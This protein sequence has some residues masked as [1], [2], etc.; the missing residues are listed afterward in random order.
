MTRAKPLDRAFL[1]WCVILAL[2]LGSPSGFAIAENIDPNEDGSQYGWGENFGW[3]NAEPGGD[4]GSGVQVN[5][6][7]LTG[8]LFA[9]NLGWISLSCQ[10]T[11]SCTTMEYGITNDGD[12][13][14]SGFGW[15]ENGGWVNFAPASGGGVTIDPATGQFNGPVWAE[16]AG[17]IH[18][19]G[20]DAVLFGVTTAWPDETG[21][22][23]GDADGD[24]NVDRN[25]LT[26][27]IAARNTP[28]T[29]PDDPRDVDQDGTIT[30]L[31][32]R[33]AALRCD[34]PLCAP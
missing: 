25:D 6:D 12:G 22:L 28:S 20:S 29:G 2:G 27:I 3:V 34:N 19:R 13:N 33:Q 21:P 4:G 14:L 1:P 30:V 16:N 31:D 5:A 9:E 15:S 32:A 17:W 26:L 7:R 8:Y 11:S 18:L 10:N 23:L 24:G